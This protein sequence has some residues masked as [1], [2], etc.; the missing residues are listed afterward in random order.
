MLFTGPVLQSSRHVWDTGIRQNLQLYPASKII[1][2]RGL[3]YNFNLIH[4]HRNSCEGRNY[5]YKNCCVGFPSEPPKRLFGK[6]SAENTT[7]L[8][9]SLT[10][11]TIR[12]PLLS[13][14][15]ADN[16]L[17]GSIIVLFII[18]LSTGFLPC[19][20]APIRLPRQLTN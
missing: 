7:A 8:H 12:I 5:I 15:T 17:P 16:W 13:L 2:V 6:A 11:K 9:P 14:Y 20:P 3:P 4:L 19:F 1:A 18:Y 10:W